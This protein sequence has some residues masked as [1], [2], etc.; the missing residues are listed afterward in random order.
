M[1][2]FISSPLLFIENNSISVNFFSDTAK[3]Y[4]KITGVALAIISSLTTLYFI[5]RHFKVREIDQDDS[6]ISPHITPFKSH[7]SNQRPIL[8]K[9]PS[10]KKKLDSIEDSDSFIEDSSIEKSPKNFLS[11]KPVVQLS[12]S[13]SDHPS[14]PSSFKIDTPK[15]VDFQTFT[16]KIA[17]KSLLIS[18]FEEMRLKAREIGQQVSDKHIKLR[19]VIPHYGLERIQAVELIEELRGVADVILTE[20]GVFHILPKKREETQEN[21]TIRRYDNGVI[22]KVQ[23]SKKDTWD[24]QGRRIY[25]NGVIETGRFDN[26]CWHSGTCIENE[27]TTYRLPDILIESHRLGRGL[28]YAEIEGEKQLIVVQKK[29]GSDNSDYV[30]VDEKLIPTF[31]EILR[32]EYVSE[33]SLQEIL[34]GPIDC[35]EFFK[36]LFETNLIFSLGEHSLESVLKIIQEKELNVNLRQQN[37]MTKETLLHCYSK[38]ARITQTL[39]AIDPN[40]IDEAEPILLKQFKNKLKDFSTYNKD[41]Q[42]IATE[43]FKNVPKSLELSELVDFILKKCRS[44][45]ILPLLDAILIAYPSF[46]LS[47]YDK[48][49]R[50]IVEDEHHSLTNSALIDMLKEHH[51]DNNEEKIIECCDL[52]YRLN[53]PYI[54]RV[55]QAP[56]LT[57]DYSLNFLWVN[58]NPQ[59]RIQDVAQ[60]IFKDGLD[61][62]ENANCIKD[63]RAL[64]ACEENEELLEGEDLKNWKKIKKSFA[65]RISKWADANPGAQINLWYDSALVTQKAQQKS[66]EMMKSISESRGVNLKLKDIRQ[67]PNIGGE[68]G[69][70]LHPGTQVYYRVDLLKALIADH[71]ISS[72]EE[73]AKYCVISDIDVKPM[74]PQ[75]MFDQRT[76]DYLSTNGY[77][78]NR[79]GLHDFENSFF[80][81]NKEKEDLQRI[82]NE[83]IIQQTASTIAELRQYPINTNFKSEDILGAQSIYNLYYRFREKMGEVFE[84]RKLAP[85]KVVKCPESQFN[86]GGSFSKSDYQKETFRFIGSSHIP[87]TRK[88]RNFNQRG[89]EG[90]I[91]E[92]IDWKSEPLPVNILTAD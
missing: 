35:E 69:N 88:G 61:L 79:V 62:S 14:L 15:K 65:Y 12:K 66:F 49:R 86:C 74:T 73:S 87:Y 11:P 20:S 2:T 28:M 91:K 38:N 80:I 19:I 78:L 8:K 68:I 7:Q 25:P 48:I 45:N 9:A 47:P 6:Q 3:K 54:Y 70:A 16:I 76:L 57:N 72:S 75:Q 50:A 84:K 26:F 59:D 4:A 22:E 33:K 43:L 30:Q 58:L 53:H 29:S 37:P 77:V 32:K 40:L 82:H 71:M 64:R 51:L 52:A 5:Y 36:F 55:S 34:S 67:L 17:E 60:N 90:Q 21:L 89:K 92:L 23:S 13:P 81:F 27:V 41:S 83:V 10:P 42:Q 18:S 31:A 85:R 1:F 39:L 46:I 24:W 44:R 56:V 63:P